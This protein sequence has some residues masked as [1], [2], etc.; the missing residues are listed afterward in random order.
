MCCFASSCPPI[1]CVELLECVITLINSIWDSLDPCNWIQM[2]LYQIDKLWNWANSEDKTFFFLFF[3]GSCYCLCSSILSQKQDI[4]Y[5]IR[6]WIWN[7]NFNSIIMS[8]IKVSLCVLGVRGVYGTRRSL[9]RQ[10]KVLW[11]GLQNTSDGYVWSDF[12][13]QTFE[14]LGFV[15]RKKFHGLVPLFLALCVYLQTPNSTWESQTNL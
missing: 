2:V 5:Q 9:V 15:K 11:S 12:K 4:L 6:T 3:S 7:R 13:N 14:D 10:K 8:L 1:I